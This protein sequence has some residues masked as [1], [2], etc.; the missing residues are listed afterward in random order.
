MLAASSCITGVEDLGMG[1]RPWSRC[2]RGWG[3][4]SWR[5]GAS[6]QQELKK[7]LSAIAKLRSLEE[8]ATWLLPF[9]SPSPS[10]GSMHYIAIWQIFLRCSFQSVDTRLRLSVFWGDLCPF[11]FHSE[12]S[13]VNMP[14][15]PSQKGTEPE[16]SVVTAPGGFVLVLKPCEG[17]NW[18]L[19]AGVNV[20]RAWGAI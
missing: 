12:A 9:H 7:P 18:S 6:Y 14:G 17:A 16:P 1:L 15:P 11:H 5:K 10:L 13:V 2:W 3:S 20:F 19:K 4:N 8:K